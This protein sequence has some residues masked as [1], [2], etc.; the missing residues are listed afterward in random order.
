MSAPGQT[1]GVSQ[2]TAAGSDAFAPLGAVP[3]YPKVP[4]EQ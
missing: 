1:R 3:R 4:V 2:Y